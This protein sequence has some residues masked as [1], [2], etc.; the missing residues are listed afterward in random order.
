MLDPEQLE[1]KRAIDRASHKISRQRTKDHIG[2]L[3]QRVA[4][5]SKSN[6]CEKLFERN[7][8]L[9]D[10]IVQLRNRLGMLKVTPSEA[11]G[12][13]DDYREYAAAASSMSST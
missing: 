8:I 9:E 3:E 5:L 7:R 2:R 11:P 10:E 6:T 1:R 12:A 4:D 13:T